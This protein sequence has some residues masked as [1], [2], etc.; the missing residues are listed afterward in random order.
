MHQPS[1]I[2]SLVP[3]VGHVRAVETVIQ[4]KKLFSYMDINGEKIILVNT[5][6]LGDKVRVF[7]G[8]LNG[9]YIENDLSFSD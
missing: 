9:A 5:Y 4:L 7:L 2:A 8:V 6:F 3:T 1:E